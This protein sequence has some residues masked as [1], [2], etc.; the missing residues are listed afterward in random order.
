MKVMRNGDTRNPWGYPN[1]VGYGFGYLIFI[2]VENWD[3]FGETR[4]LRVWVWEMQNPS[5]IR[6]IAMSSFIQRILKMKERDM[7]LCMISF[8]V[9]LKIEIG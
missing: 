7:L 4:I 6:P 3:G 8:V 9:I 2:P 1:P 5:P